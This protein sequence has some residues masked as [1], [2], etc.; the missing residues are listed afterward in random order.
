MFPKR[1]RTQ[2]HLRQR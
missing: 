2:I 1:E